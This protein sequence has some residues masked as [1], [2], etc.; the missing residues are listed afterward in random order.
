MQ[1]F[2]ENAPDLSDCRSEWILS[3]G[4]YVE[5]A[6]SPV[7]TDVANEILLHIRRNGI[8][9]L[10]LRYKSELEDSKYAFEFVLRA[11]WW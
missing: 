10:I 6:A 4:R 2:P 7:L 11:C 8:L 9:L 1:W 5:D 3:E